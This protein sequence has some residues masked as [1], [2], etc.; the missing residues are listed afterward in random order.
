MK[1]VYVDEKEG[2]RWRSCRLYTIGL[3]EIGVCGWERR[4]QMAQLQAV[5]HWLIWNWCMWMRKKVP[6]GAVAG[7]TPLA[8]MKLVY[9]DEKEGS[10]WRSCRLYTIGLYEIGVCGWERRFQMAQLQTVHHWLYHQI[11]VTLLMP[12]GKLIFRRGILAS[13]LSVRVEQIISHWTDFYSILYLRFSEHLSTQ[14]KRHENLALYL[15]TY[16]HLLLL[17]LSFS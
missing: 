11:C 6:D 12:V 5:H 1:L 8:Y 16:V 9:V 15:K 17:T 4:F 7:C 14:F 10:R 2:S 3:Y 13:C